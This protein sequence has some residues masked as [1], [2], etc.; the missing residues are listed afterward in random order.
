M[1]FLLFTISIIAALLFGW[2]LA[3]VNNSTSKAKRIFG[4]FLLG[5]LALVS[6]ICAI[7]V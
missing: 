4:R 3:K 5:G 2:N 7:S 6:I 1:T